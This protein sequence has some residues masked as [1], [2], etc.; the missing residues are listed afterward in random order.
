MKVVIDPA[1]EKNPEV[2]DAVRQGNTSLAGM[3]DLHGD[4]V[5]V[6]WAFRPNRPDLTLL[7]I[8][9][10]DDATAEA[11]TIM[12]LSILTSDMRRDI[13]IGGTVSR[14]ADQ[15]FLVHHHRLRELLAA[16]KD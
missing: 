10:L 9:S 1:I 5:E 3:L 16:T 14:W 4:D 6:S 11:F 2:L 15:K 8:R 13:A 12:P 7:T